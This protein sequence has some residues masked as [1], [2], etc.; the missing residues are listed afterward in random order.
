MSRDIVGFASATEVVLRLTCRVGPDN[1][2]GMNATVAKVR[3]GSTAP[4]N[5]AGAGW[6]ENGGRLGINAVAAAGLDHLMVGDH[7]SFFGGAGVDGL[8]AA[9]NALGCQPDL[10]VYVA[11]YQ[12]FLRHPV[13][14]ARQLADLAL[15]APGQLTF[16][17]GLG[18]ED[19]HESEVCGVDPA[20]R[21]RRTDECLEVLTRLLAG[22]SVTFEGQAITVT[23][24]LIR[25]TPRSRIPIVI[26]GR[27]DAA[28]QRAARFGDGWIGIWI[29]AT[30]FAEAVRHVEQ[31]AADGGRPAT[32]W[33]HALN[34]WC[35]LSEDRAAAR[36]AVAQG[37]QD[38]YHLPYESFA[39]WS[40]AG[41]PS[42]VAEFLAPYI[43]AG[44]S[45]FNLIPCGPDPA[46]TPWLAAE[47]R[48][49]LV[50][51]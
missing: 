22:D 30:R 27:S 42:D 16:G 2:E 32:G 31:R 51:A 3:V 43:E 10:P 5:P 4:V 6:L 35:G 12:L 23:D 44:C 50:S 37:M 39:R 8:I 26:G 24:A 45:T 49:L 20:T 29:S 40:P 18:G 1:L 25:P 36:D 14:V 19:R 47:V 7:V 21:G 46:E 28:L 34:V 48:K 13:S 33:S 9:A 15:M 41:N 38:F 17:V 11:V